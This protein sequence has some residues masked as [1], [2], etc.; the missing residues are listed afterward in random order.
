MPAA[1]RHAKPSKP[2]R[3]FGVP[4]VAVAALAGAAAAFVF[5]QSG[6][7]TAAPAAA[8]TGFINDELVTSVRRD[9]AGVQSTMVQRAA[10]A[11]AAAARHRRLARQAVRPAT[12]A[13]PSPTPTATAPA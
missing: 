11:A 1:S 12:S 9:V 3:R 5:F 6:P 2:V 4:I 13:T 10:A 7:V 8:R